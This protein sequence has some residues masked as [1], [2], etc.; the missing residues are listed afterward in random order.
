MDEDHAAA[1]RLRGSGFELIGH[2][3][4]AKRL[5]PAEHGRC[6]QRFAPARRAPVRGQVG[7]G[8]GSSRLD[9]PQRHELDREDQ[10]SSPSGSRQ[11]LPAAM[12]RRVAPMPGQPSQRAAGHEQEVVACC[13][14]ARAE[15]ECIGRLSHAPGE[16][17]VE[18]PRLDRLG[19]CMEAA[20]KIRNAVAEVALLRH[21]RGGRPA[22][23]ARAGTRSSVSSRGASPAPTRT[24][25]PAGPMRRRRGFSW[26]SS[27]ATRTMPSATR[28]SR[29]SR[30]RSKS[31]SPRRSRTP[32]SPWRE[33]HALTEELD[34]AMAL[35]WLAQATA[36]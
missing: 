13:R 25:W 31:C 11:S 12:Q 9:E 20:Q 14:R 1:R 8:A 30:A 4:P 36:T 15:C 29:A 10:R 7:R 35:A 22:A 26:R 3:P 28:S 18:R 19:V 33:L 17:S 2:A 34:Q 5:A 6:R 21:R 32:P 16:A 27:T 24:C 23:A